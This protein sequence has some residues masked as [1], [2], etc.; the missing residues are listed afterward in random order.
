MKKILFICVQNSARSQIAEG[1][2]RHLKGT[3]MEFASAGSVP[4]GRV[5]PMAVKVMA[6]VGIDISKH[7]SQSIDEFPPETVDRYIALCAEESCPAVGKPIESWALPDP[8]N[9][10]NETPEQELERFRKT[11]DVIRKMVEGL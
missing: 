9:R 4:S 5:H 3:E 1:F 10:E 8:A 7:K 6:E 2:A 11:R